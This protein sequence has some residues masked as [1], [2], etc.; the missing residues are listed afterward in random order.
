[1][2]A[3]ATADRAAADLADIL[4]ALNRL[5]DSKNAVMP[6]G[7]QQS[8]LAGLADLPSELIVAA[9]VRLSRASTFGLPSVGDIRLEAD[10]VQREAASERQ[11]RALPARQSGGEDDRRSWVHC[12]DCQDEPNAWRTF[13]CNGSGRLHVAN[14]QETDPTTGRVSRGQGLPLSTCGRG[15]QH[16]PHTFTE[17]CACH[18]APWRAERRARIHKYGDD[19]KTA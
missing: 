9:C 11:Q 2:T 16:N 6:K 4:A 13:W 18:T 15:G 14:S 17:R 12:Q 10:Q 3:P 1:M 19:R 7:Q 5:A 8:Y